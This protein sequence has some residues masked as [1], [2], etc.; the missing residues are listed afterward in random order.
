MTKALFG[1]SIA[2]HAVH[3][4]PHAG[5]A[6]WTRADEYAALDPPPLTTELPRLGRHATEDLIQI[7]MVEAGR[8]SVDRERKARNLEQSARLGLAWDL[9]HERQRP[10]P[11]DPM[12]WMELL[13]AAQAYLEATTRSEGVHHQVQPTAIEISDMY[14]VE[15]VNPPAKT[16]ASAIAGEGISS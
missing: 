7:G 13:A 6:E 14:E 10:V 15:A 9:R 2:P 3:I 5:N 4:E 12:T 16:S 11:V 1:G 8:A